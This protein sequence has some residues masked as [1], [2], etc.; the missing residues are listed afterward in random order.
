MI[1]QE[2][3]AFL[4]DLSENNNRE[5]FAANKHRY[6]FARLELEHFTEKVLLL[7]KQIDPSIPTDLSAKKCILRIY[8]DIRFSKNKMPYKNNFAINISTVEKGKEGPGYY[9]HIAPQ[10]SFVAGGYWMPQ[11]TD[12]KAIRQEIDYNTADF[13]KVIE[14]PEFNKYFGSLSIEDKLRLAP[15]DYPKD[16]PYIDLLKL[17]SFICLHSLSDEILKSKDGLKEIEKGLKLLYPFQMFL[18]NAI[19]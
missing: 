3:F 10:A 7:I 16:H 6:D 17:K 11:A 14:D 5:W 2:I 15:K 9:I 13:L 1:K 8:R 12:L 18:K 19:S 4:K